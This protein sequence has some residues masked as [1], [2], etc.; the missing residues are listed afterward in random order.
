MVTKK[1]AVTDAELA[2][3]K[4]VMAVAGYDVP[5]VDD[6]KSA[7]DAVWSK[8]G[9]ED[10]FLLAGCQGMD[11]GAKYVW[12]ALAEESTGDEKSYWMKKIEN[13]IC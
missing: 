1:D 13:R 2:A 9:E 12:E 10:V 4:E 3:F 11:H 7:I 6:L 5:V 8:V